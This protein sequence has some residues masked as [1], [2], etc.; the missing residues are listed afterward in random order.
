MGRQTETDN[1]SDVLDIDSRKGVLIFFGFLIICGC[2]FVAGYVMG[3]KAAPQPEKYADAGNTGNISRKENTGAESYNRSNEK[4]GEPVTLPPAVIEPPP[5]QTEII[6]P[7]AA[8]TGSEQREQ[9]EAAPDNSPAVSVPAVSAPVLADKPKPQSKETPQK[10]ETPNKAAA[11]TAEKTTSPA[12]QASSAKPVYSVQVAAFRARREAEIKSRE[13]EAKGF[14]SRIEPP[15]TPGDYYR[16]KVGNFTT[17]AAA[18]EMAERLK[19]SG[20]D[21]M[22]SES[23]GN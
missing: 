18:A 22:I 10:K 20:F 6:V 12:K 17:R 3:N 13:L 2:F 9:L 16:L 21:T 14:E 23:K 19:K 7:A 11:P 1:E 5:A 8:V 4:S 15:P